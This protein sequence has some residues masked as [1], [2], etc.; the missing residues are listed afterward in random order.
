VSVA[1]VSAEEIETLNEELQSSNEE[2]ETLHEEAQATVEELNVANDELQARSTELEIKSQE[3]AE[4]AEALR[5]L[6]RRLLIVQEEERRNLARELHDEIGQV[7]TGL[8]FQLTSAAEQGNVG[9]LQEAS[10]AV[11]RLT[12]QVRQLSLDL[13]P[14][15]LDRYGLLVAVQWYIDRFQTTTGITVHLRAQD[16]EQQR[17]AAEVEIAAF[18]V[19]QEALTN[20]ARYAGVREAWVKLLH[21]GSL[22]L[23]IHDLGQGFAPER[24]RESSGLSGMR[25]RVELLGGSF[26]LEAA[27]GDGVHITAEFPLEEPDP[28]AGQLRSAETELETPA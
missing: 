5:M 1:Q 6:S 8:S 22:L 18:R 26:V 20:I 17:F 11:Q 24:Y 14:Q 16:V 7:L 12:E 25:E 23:V 19:V 10:A 28:E 21:D 3:H 9:A 27:P 2:L 13:R 4:L 15:V